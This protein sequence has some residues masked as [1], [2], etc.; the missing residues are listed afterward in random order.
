MKN[1]LMA[2]GMQ[3]VI[4]LISKHSPDTLISMMDKMRVHGLTRMKNYHTGTP[5][6][7]VRR[8]DAAN[9]F[10]EMAKRKMNDLSPNTQKRLAFNAFFNAIN[11]GDEKREEYFKKHGEYPPFFL[12][13]SPSMACDL[14]CFGCYAWKYPKNKGL[15]K[16]KMSEIITE[17]KEE[18][19]IYF[20]SITGGEP[21]YWPHLEAMA[22]E[23][24]DVMFQIYTHGQSIDDAT[25]KRYSELGNIYPAISIEGDEKLTDQRRGKGAYKKVLEAMD[26]LHR[27]GCLFG[28]SLTHTA[29]NHDYT[30]S[31]EFI[32]TLVEHGAA[33]GWYFQYIPVGRDPQWELVPSAEQRLERREVVHTI[34]KEK[35]ILVY[36]FWNDGDSVDGCIAWGRKYV[37]ITASGY[38]EPCVFLHFAKDSVNDKT[39]GECL[40]SDVFTEARRRQPFTEDLRMPCPQIDHPEILKELVDTYGM[41][42]THEGAE[43]IITEHHE[44]VCQTARA[45]R[46]VLD[47]YDKAAAECGGGCA[48][49]GT[50]RRAVEAAGD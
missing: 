5:E 46:A 27:H 42:P 17:A 20:I 14:K 21:T 23:H 16:E 44:T 32:D 31:D 19:G 29:L 43:G 8:V 4:P 9:S 39:L 49:C 6:E 48:S 36:D 40:R 11:L 10:F 1:F 33:F 24:P 26:H 34:R 38:V 7:L 30:C 25:A 12:L 35:P 45:Y 2:K 22:A 3:S 28:F 15:S 50:P 47:S 13:I 18:M 37:H 41:V